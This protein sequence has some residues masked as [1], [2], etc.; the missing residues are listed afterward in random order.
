MG[1][2]QDTPAAIIFQVTKQLKEDLSLVQDIDLVD[3]QQDVLEG[4][5]RLLLLM[6][7]PDALIRLQKTEL[8]EEQKKLCGIYFDEQKH[9]SL[10]DFVNSQLELSQENGALLQ[11]IMNLQCMLQLN[12]IY[13]FLDNNSQ[14]SSF[15][16]GDQ[17]A[18]QNIRIHSS[19]DILIFATRV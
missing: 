10:T 1:F 9:D 13:V 14:S 2:Q 3:Y 15:K 4:S 16:Y 8:R 12:S 19:T 18:E 7:S 17:G 6:T 5:Y 11:V